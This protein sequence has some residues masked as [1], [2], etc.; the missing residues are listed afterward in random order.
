[1]QDLAHGPAPLVRFEQQRPE[2]ENNACNLAFDPGFLDR[3]HGRP[4]LL[5]DDVLHELGH[6]VKVEPYA[7][8]LADIQQHTAETLEL[9]PHAAD[10]TVKRTFRV[11]PLWAVRPS[12]LESGG[13]LAQI[14]CCHGS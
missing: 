9:H 1:M 11:Q 3:L 4:A 14:G 7:V 12:R 8:R 2:P 6:F 5:R 10:G 13:K